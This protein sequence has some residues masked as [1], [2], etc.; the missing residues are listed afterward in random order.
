MGSALGT[1]VGTA[2]GSALGLALGTNVGAATSSALG[3]GVGAAT[4]SALGTGVGATVG[5]RFRN[6]V[7]LLER[8]GRRLIIAAGGKT[9]LLDGAIE[10][11]PL[12]RAI[13]PHEG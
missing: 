6:R 5:P 12:D 10:G 4:G 1:G 2:T 13:G 11:L 8:E 3:T 9:E 7:G